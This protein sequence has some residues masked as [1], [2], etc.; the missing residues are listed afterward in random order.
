MRKKVGKRKMTQLVFMWMVFSSLLFPQQPK[1][2]PRPPTAGAVD[3][4]IFRGFPFAQKTSRAE[5][6]AVL[7]RPS[8]ASAK[9]L[10][11]P[12]LRVML[13]ELKDQSSTVSS[14]ELSDN[15]WHFPAKLRIGSSRDE[16]VKLLGKPDVERPSESIYGCYECVYDH[17]IHFIFDG[18]KVKRILWDFYLP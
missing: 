1:L 18:S 16:V 9:K 15:R 7:G 5:L 8:S 13:A 6:E 3:E 2:T 12:G 14:I 10:E 4:I 11:F 17:K